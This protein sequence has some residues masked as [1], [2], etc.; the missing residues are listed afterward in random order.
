MGGARDAAL[1]AWRDVP[2]T[3]W[4]VASLI[5]PAPGA[6]MS[7]MASLP[8]SVGVAGGPDWSTPTE[9]PSLLSK[10]AACDSITSVD[11][12][13][14]GASHP[15]TLRETLGAVTDFIASSRALR[16]LQCRSNGFGMQ[17]RSI[18]AP[19]RELYLPP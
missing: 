4:G 5:K 12:S 13:N 8:R 1:C 14:H 19:P 7:R 9:L 16:T 6:P 15:D 3:W 2:L 11:L 10:L 17:A 18:R